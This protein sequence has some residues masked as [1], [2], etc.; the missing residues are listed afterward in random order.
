MIC[1]W[2][3]SSKLKKLLKYSVGWYVIE[4]SLQKLKKLLKY[5]VGWYVIEG[6]LQKLKKLLKYSVGWLC[7][8]SVGLACRL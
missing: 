2:R 8:C 1:Y 6:S 7:Y 3:I 4:G 5:S